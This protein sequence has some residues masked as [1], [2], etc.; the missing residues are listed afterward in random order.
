MLDTNYNNKRNKNKS[1]I[2]NFT[3]KLKKRYLLY[4]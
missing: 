3:A 2:V 4:K 1:R